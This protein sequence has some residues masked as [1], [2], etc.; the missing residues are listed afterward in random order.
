MKQHSEDKL[1]TS[2]QYTEVLN[3]RCISPRN[4]I[5]VIQFKSDVFV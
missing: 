3:I 2:L 4:I 1:E 5:T